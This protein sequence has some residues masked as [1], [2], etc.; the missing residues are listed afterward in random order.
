MQVSIDI[1]LEHG[2][3]RV[4]GS[5]SGCRLDTLEAKFGEIKLVDE[6]ID[7]ADRVIRIHIILKTRRQKARL[8]T[9]STFNETT[10]MAPPK[11]CQIIP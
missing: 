1:E 8:L 11:Q 6:G 7:D 9:V 2:A 4:A 5:A 3:W 10:H